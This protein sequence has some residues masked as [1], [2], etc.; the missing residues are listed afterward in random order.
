M[1]LWV[2]FFLGSGLVILVGFLVLLGGAKSFLTSGVRLS[3]ACERTHGLRSGS[4]VK[5]IDLAVGSV[6]KV[7][8][9]QAGNVTVVFSVSKEYH[10]IV[11]QLP[12]NFDTT[13][14]SVVTLKMAGMGIGDS[15]LEIN[16]GDPTLPVVR[17][18]QTMPFAMPKDKLDETMGS[19]KKLVD[20]LND[21]RHTL[22]K[23][24]HDEGAYYAEIYKMLKN[25]AEITAKM[26]AMMEQMM[27]K[28][29]TVGAFLND[30]KFYD[31]LV[32]VQEQSRKLMDGLIDITK[33]AT[34]VSR[35]FADLAGK[36]HAL[37]D[38]ISVMMKKGDVAVD[39]LATVL[40]KT[41]V[42]TDQFIVIAKT[43][44]EVSGSLPELTERGVQ[45]MTSARDVMNAL[46]SN[47]L[48]RP[49]IPQP[50]ADRL[51][52]TV[53]RGSGQ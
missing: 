17:D 50:S 48:I 11:R 14:G 20:A 45:T 16:K 34:E 22:G 41:E 25:S 2:G 39:Q 44:A 7:D 26:S 5:M 23:M 30:R 10:N 47:F 37:F 15:F 29:G 28:D 12:D 46:K 19:V 3:I 27:S 38:N 21:D 18:G 52:E 42:M 1:D 33:N 40:K 49:F 24:L 51:L 35:Q 6:E 32:A 13:K 8:V 53:P 43:L 4:L 31:N 9:D 36:Q